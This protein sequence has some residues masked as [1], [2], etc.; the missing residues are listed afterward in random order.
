MKI[1]IPNTWMGE[2]IEGSIERVFKNKEKPLLKT[3]SIKTHNPARNINDPEN[4]LILEERKHG[5]YE[6]PDLLV[7][8]ERTH[9]NKNWSEAW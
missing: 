8:M 1:Q 3:P 2:P 4:Y 5:T 7:S 6:Y 9:K